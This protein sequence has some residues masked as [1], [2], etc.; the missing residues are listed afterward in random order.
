MTWQEILV[1]LVGIVLTALASW[2][3]A[4]LTTL[5][6]TKVKDAKTR[7]FLNSAI[8]VVSRTVKV[9][10]QTFV[11]NIKGTDKWTEETQKEALRR[12]IEAARSQL[13]SDIQ[14]YIAKGGMT[15]DEWL[16]QQIEAMIYTLKAQNGKS[17]EGS[18]ETA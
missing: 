14:D 9:T 15:V 1:T 5:I 4:W 17:G 3:V 16:R 12:A 2:L 13:S 10:Y 7:A 18:D 6:N 11:S 8:E